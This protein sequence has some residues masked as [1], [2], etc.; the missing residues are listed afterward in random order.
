ME[1]VW[2]RECECWRCGRASGSQCVR[3]WVWVRVCA[4]LNIY[5]YVNLCICLGM[6]ECIC[7]GWTCICAGKNEG[8]VLGLGIYICMHV[9]EYVDMSGFVGGH[10][11]SCVRLYM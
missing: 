6:D 8:V 4:R 9:R 10:L 3:E 1:W 2:A 5:V 11:Y 7:R